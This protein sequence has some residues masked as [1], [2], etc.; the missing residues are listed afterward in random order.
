MHVALDLRVAGALK[1][2]LP[3]IEQLLCRVLVEPPAC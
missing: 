1:L 3:S 2:E